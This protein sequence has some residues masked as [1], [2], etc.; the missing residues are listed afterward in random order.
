MKTQKT[1][2][3]NEAI[4][5]RAGNPAYPGVQQ[6]DQRRR[7]KTV[8]ENQQFRLNPVQSE[9]QLGHEQWNELVTTKANRDTSGPSVFLFFSIDKHSKLFSVPQ[10]I[11]RWPLSVSVY[12]DN[13]QLAPVASFP[14]PRNQINNHAKTNR[15]ALAN[16]NQTPLCYVPG[17]WQDDRGLKETICE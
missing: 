17:S 4:I 8:S 14:S 11:Q 10:V 15:A 5:F 2:A 16:T 1:Q 3:T 7:L 13:S 12:G 6:N 9:P